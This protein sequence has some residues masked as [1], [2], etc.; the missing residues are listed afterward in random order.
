MQLLL[1]RVTLANLILCI[2]IVILSIIGYVKI[3][4]PTQ[5]FIGAVFF[6]SGVSHVVSS[7]DLKTALEQ[8]MI[9]APDRNGRKRKAGRRVWRLGV[10]HGA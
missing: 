7:P 9:R 2:M 10:H 6:L 4:S 3:R 5:L 8:E 1:D